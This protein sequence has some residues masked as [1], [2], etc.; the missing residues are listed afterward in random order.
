MRGRATYHRSGSG[1]TRVPR[2]VELGRW[3]WPAFGFVMVP[4]ITGLL[5]PFAVLSY[6]A[7]RGASRGAGADVLWAPLQ[8]SLYIALLTSAAAVA[9]ALPVAVLAVR[10]R[11]LFS[12]GLERVTYL[13]FGL[14]GIAVAL[15]LVFFGVN[16]APPLYQ[17]TGLLVFACA[18]LFVPAAVGPLRASL[19]QVSPRVEEAARALGVRPL[20]VALRVTA[21]LVLPGALAGAGMV[22]LLTMKELPAT[23]ILSPVGFQ[24]LATTIWSSASE[25]MLARAA[26]PALLLVVAAGAPTAWFVLRGPAGSGQ[27]APSPRRSPSAAE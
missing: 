13:G 8:N 18:V 9:A 5:V 25:A 10:Y 23:L 24:T 19:L 17:T 20:G 1:A 2:P 12:R 14:P 26:L 15:S 4:V 27:P 3:R 11:G 16:V 21:P 6:W 22:F 7:V